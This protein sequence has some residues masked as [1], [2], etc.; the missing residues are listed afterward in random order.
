MRKVRCREASVSLFTGRF[1][2]FPVHIYYILFLFNQTR[3]TQSVFFSVC[4]LCSCLRSFSTQHGTHPAPRV[5]DALPPGDARTFHNTRTIN[6]LRVHLATF[7]TGQPNCTD[8]FSLDVCPNLKNAE[9]YGQHGGCFYHSPRGSARMRQA[10]PPGQ[11][12]AL[13]A[14]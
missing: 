1:P 5:T 7:M 9:I 2:L 10:E 13:P 12:S 11:N 4:F 14:V 3:R 8:N 6:V